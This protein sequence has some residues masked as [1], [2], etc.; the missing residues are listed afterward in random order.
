M[1]ETYDLIVV[2]GGIGGSALA[3][4][5]AKAGHRVLLLEKSTVYEDHVRGEWIAPWGVAEV[6][7]LGLYDLLVGSGG[8]HLAKH[9]SYDETRA[10]EAAEAE[11]LP[12]DMFVPGVP[13]P[14][15]LGHPKHCQTLYDEALRAGATGLRGVN[16]TKTEPG[17]KPRVEFVH[18]GQTRQAEAKLVIGADG[19]ASAVRAACGIELH[20]DKPHHMFGGLLVEGADGWDATKQAIGTEGD[21]AFLAFPQG[22]G[23]VRVYGNY[24]LNERRR[25]AGENGAR[26]FLEA[27]RM[28]CAPEN[29]HLADA[30]PAGPLLSYFNNDS[31]TD[32]P[33][34]QGAVLVGDA[35]GW[36]DPINGLGLSITYRDVRM[37]SELLKENEEW[38]PALFKPYGEERYERMRRL[39]FAGQLQA[40]LDAEFGEEARERRRSYDE[41]KAANPALGAHAFAI[42]AGPETLPP[43]MF[44]E[45]HRANVL[46]TRVKGEVE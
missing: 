16:V 3:A 2:G 27:F 34:V 21:F 12:L 15:C 41:R 45:E 9:V 29:K 11:P 37:V 4:T 24:S 17:M 14:L 44:T 22:G 32:A 42:M 20:Q 30:K 6:K 25:F 10:P 13:G 26:D 8:H 46:G 39:R 38:G 1:N 35:A 7:R 5:M 33:F 31:W 19:R 40:T 23:R 18:D 36:N 28:K 43:E